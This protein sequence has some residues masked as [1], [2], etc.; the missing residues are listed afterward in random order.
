MTGV[1]DHAAPAPIT[2]TG[3][4]LVTPS[5]SLNTTETVSV[6]S[7]EPLWRANSRRV[8]CSMPMHIGAV[9]ADAP[10]GSA[11]ERSPA[12]YGLLPSTTFAPS[13]SVQSP[14]PPSTPPSGAETYQATSS[15]G[16]NVC[17]SGC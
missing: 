17:E 3:S 14:A 13:V 5:R 1:G 12:R 10:P 16:K 15:H 4:D 11:S 2:P 7:G 9:V 8:G 6:E